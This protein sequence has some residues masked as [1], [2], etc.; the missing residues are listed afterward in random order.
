MSLIRLNDVTVKY[1]ST[2][3]LREAFFRLEAG[4]RVGLIGRN[5]SG[6]TTLLK[7]VLEQV[8]PETGTVTIEPGLRIGYFSQFSELDGTATITEVLDGAVRRGPRGRGRAGR[9]RRRHRRGLLGEHRAR[10]PHRPPV[11]AVR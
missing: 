1:E 7:L 3:I 11:R 6:K 10:P 9:H 2:Q 4:D 8:Q 5:G